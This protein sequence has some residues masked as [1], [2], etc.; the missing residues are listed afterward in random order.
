[1][2]QM[3][4]YTKRCQG[5]QIKIRIEN[6]FGYRIQEIYFNGEYLKKDNTYRIVYITQ[7]GVPDKYITPKTNLDIH[8]VEAMVNYLKKL[9]VTDKLIPAFSLV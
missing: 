2:K 8:A 9:P 4:G 6:P 5:L 3:G 7:Q 1:M